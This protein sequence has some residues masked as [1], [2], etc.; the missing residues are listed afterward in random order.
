MNIGIFG[1]SF[2]PIHLGHTALANYILRL[3]LVDEVWLMV[4]PHNPLKDDDTLLCED[5]RLELARLATHGHPGI[6]ASDFEFRLP[7]PSYTYVTLRELTLAYPEHT[8]SLIIGADNWELFPRWRH[9]GLILSHHRVIVYP[10][11][12][13]GLHPVSQPDA[14]NPI[15]L[16]EA[17]LLPVSSTAIREAIAEGRDASLWLHPNVLS[18]IHELGLYRPT[19]SAASSHDEPTPAGNTSE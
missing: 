10:R 4:S 13:E 11:D 17:P 9:S 15:F 18:R 6:H 12:G 16:P 5:L 2:N 19:P 1:G 14:P 3:G 7:R 8:F